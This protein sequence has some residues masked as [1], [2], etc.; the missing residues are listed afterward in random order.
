M[1]LAKRYDD[2]ITLDNHVYWA[3]REKQQIG[4]E[5]R[6]LEVTKVVISRMGNTSCGRGM[7][8]TLAKPTSFFQVKSGYAFVSSYDPSGI[9]LGVFMY[10][11]FLWNGS[12]GE[13][14]VA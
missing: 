7:M 2:D 10:Q 6:R 12:C 1:I 11:F 14:H 13:D 5:P 8:D 3:V 9:P 4:R